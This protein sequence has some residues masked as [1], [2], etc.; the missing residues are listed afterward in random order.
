MHRE[1]ILLAGVI[2]AAC[3]PPNGETNS[4]P[5]ARQA[6]FDTVQVHGTVAVV[7]SA[8]VDIAV[9]IQGEDG[10][11]SRV[12][13]PLAEE[14]GRLAGAEVEVTGIRERDP[15]YGQAVHADRYVIRAVDGRPV[16]TGMV[17]EAPG[18][19]L[20]LRTEDG[21]VVRLVNGPDQIRPGQK[22]WIQGSATVQV[23]S[24]G[25]IRP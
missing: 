7:G 24:F 4:I 8:P 11:S 25:V 5:P 1:T 6:G 12:E 16:I 2:M 14:I 15:R 20:Q 23:Q 22:V 10:E 9:I 21:A 19:G 18:G 17:E 3:A 13:G